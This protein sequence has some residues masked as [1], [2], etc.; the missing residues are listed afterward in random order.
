MNEKTNK[1]RSRWLAF[2]AG[3]LVTLAIVCV[4]SIASKFSQGLAQ[5]GRPIVC[6]DDAV[7]NRFAERGINLPTSAHHL[8]HAIA[9]FVDH[10]EFIGFSTAPEDTLPCAISYAKQRTNSPTFVTGTRSK[11]D[12]INKG[13]QIWGK[14]WATPLWDITTV[15][16]G[17][18]FEVE[19]T[20][21]LVD[22]DK[23]RIYI[24]TWS[25]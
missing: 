4:V 17:Q 8:Y 25:E 19:H 12:F 15:T 16:N 11:Y 22:T 6:S 23:N 7:R 1:P 2:L 18:L 3:A 5:W 13:P 10:S 24:A 20:F 14:Q 9:G 21:I